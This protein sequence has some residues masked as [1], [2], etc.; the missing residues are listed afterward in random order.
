MIIFD[1]NNKAY[2]L[3]TMLA[4]LL[5]YLASVFIVYKNFFKLDENLSH[6]IYMRL[7]GLIINFLRNI[8]PGESTGWYGL[9]AAIILIAGAGGALFKGLRVKVKNSIWK[10][11]LTSVVGSQLVSFSV[12]LVIYVLGDK[13]YSEESLIPNFLF[14]LIGAAVHGVF[15]GFAIYSIKSAGF[16]ALVCGLTGVLIGIFLMVTYGM[17]AFDYRAIAASFGA[18]SRLSIK[19]YEM[20]KLKE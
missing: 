5:A 16:F 11:A 3:F 17:R 20:I 4:G 10:I 12:Y 8:I 18:T 9:F 7:A 6:R 13:V 14:F 19:L 2:P 1:K 15:I